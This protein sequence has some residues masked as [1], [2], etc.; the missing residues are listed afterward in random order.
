ME[1]RTQTDTGMIPTDDAVRAVLNT[2]IDPCSTAARVPAGLDTMGLV[3]AVCVKHGVNGASIAITIDVTHPFCMM[4]AV[5]LAEAQKR[6]AAMPGVVSV[7]VSLHRGDL[8]TP[9]RMAPQ[10]RD[11]L[12]AL[13]D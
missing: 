7:D 8:W 13:A 10:Y 4:A 11:R 6:A 2:I 5:F 12:A 3:R 1:R 9:D